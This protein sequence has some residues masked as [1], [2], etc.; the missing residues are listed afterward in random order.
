ML[1][2]CKHMKWNSQRQPQ[3]LHQQ[4]QTSSL[5]QQADT[6]V[7]TVNTTD[8]DRNGSTVIP[9][10]DPKTVTTPAIDNDTSTHAKLPM[11]TEF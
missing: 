8:M 10:T 3:H 7:S 6:S 4:L 2:K 11:D 1:N 5:Q 9:E